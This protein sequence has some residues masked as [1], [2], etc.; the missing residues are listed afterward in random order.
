MRSLLTH[1]FRRPTLV[2]WFCV[3]VLIGLGLGR[4]ILIP[5]F[6]IWP[7]LAL[8]LVCVR[9]YRLGL[10]VAVIILGISAGGVRAGAVTQS[11]ANYTSL[12]GRLVTVHGFAVDDAVYGKQTQLVFDIQH[13]TDAQGHKLPGKIGVKGFGANAVFRNDSV[14][15]T[16]KVNPGKGSYMG[17]MSFATL[18]VSHNKPTILDTI[19]RTFNAGII[20]ALPEPLG[21]FGLGLL[22]GQRNTLPAT[23]TTD[24]KHVGLTHIIAVSGYNL[25]II[26]L[27]SR[28]FLGKRSKYQFTVA[29]LGLIGVFLLLAGG[30]PSIIRAAFVSTLSLAAWYYGR[31]FKPYVLIVL[32]AAITG[33]VNPLY[34]WSDAGWWLSFLA[35]YGVMIVSPLLAPRLVRSKRMRKSI[36]VSVALESICA[37]LM[38]VPYVLHTFGQVSLIGLVANV[39]VTALVPLGMLLALVA[40]LAG[41]L[42]PMVAGWLAWPAMV[43]LTYMLDTAHILASLPHV[44]IDNVS[45]STA[46]MLSIYVVI[47]GTTILLMH[48]TKPEQLDYDI[49][50][51]ENAIDNSLAGKLAI[52]RMYT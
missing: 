41:T 2:A 45:L 48:N 37:E 11:V 22:I 33:Y 44:F 12:Y 40:G 1:R 29:S 10:L 15:V 47:L 52:K 31:N 24:L 23:T 25:T 4:I 38:T 19:R 39:L 7:A 26:L 17:W 21:S 34:V 50:T 30:S 35:F 3:S 49:I 36:V 20:S 42:V 27:A 43:L 9:S 51:D 14:T 8:V 28:R 16:A 46:G 6:V 32:A 18:N 13:I 5:S